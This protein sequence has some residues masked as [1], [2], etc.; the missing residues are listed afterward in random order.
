MVVM[1]PDDSSAHVLG[2]R[3]AA[4]MLAGRLPAVSALCERRRARSRRA[5]ALAG[6]ERGTA[7][8]G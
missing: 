6:C 4:R 7:R 5:I 3:S 2:E 1:T 8:P